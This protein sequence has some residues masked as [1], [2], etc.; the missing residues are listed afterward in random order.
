MVPWC[1][2]RMVRCHARPYPVLADA[3]V[4]GV[5]VGVNT[6]SMYPRVPK[7]VRWRDPISTKEVYALRKGR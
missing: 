2:G 4:T 1:D 7:I 6:A 5:S 3:G